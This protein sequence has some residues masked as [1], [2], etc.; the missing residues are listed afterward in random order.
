MRPTLGQAW[1]NFR[2]GAEDLNPAEGWTPELVAEFTFISGAHW[3]LAQLVKHSSR[4]GDTGA[5]DRAAE[6][7]AEANAI[8]RQI[9][10]EAGT[11]P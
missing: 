1:R 2:D 6:L 8:T 10:N 3:A 4:L 7:L 5:T 9:E 11:S